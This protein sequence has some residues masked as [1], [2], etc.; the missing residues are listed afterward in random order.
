MTLTKAQS[1]TFA[2]SGQKLTLLGYTNFNASFDSRGDYFVTIRAWF[3]A[4]DGCKLKILGM[5]FLS[6]STKSIDFSTPKLEL[7]MCPGVS[8]IISNIKSKTIHL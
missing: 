5:D 6:N 2:V 4:K 7:K 1:K 8:I 3:A